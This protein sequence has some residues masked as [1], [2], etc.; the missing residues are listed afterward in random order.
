M[1]WLSEILPF[2]ELI[3]LIVVN[4]TKDFNDSLLAVVC[5][6]SFYL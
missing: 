2:V 3:T 5:L 6:I 4:K 1:T